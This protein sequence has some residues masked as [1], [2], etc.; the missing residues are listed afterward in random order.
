VYLLA[1]VA[2]TKSRVD[3]V[4]VML[5]RYVKQMCTIG[6]F[7]DRIGFAAAA[8]QYAPHVDDDDQDPPNSLGLSRG[9]VAAIAISAVIAAAA[10]TY[11]A[12]ISCRHRAL[13][14]QQSS[15]SAEAGSNKPETALSDLHPQ[16][17][18]LDLSAELA[19]QHGSEEHINVSS[20]LVERSPYDDTMVR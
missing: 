2:I 18:E 17:S 7:R 9:T 14:R 6:V 4:S 12:Y 16:S 5:A 11:L 13:M 8:G 20:R 3:R 15:R 10:L 19:D 1:D